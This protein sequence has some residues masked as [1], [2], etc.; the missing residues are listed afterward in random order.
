MGSGWR[1]CLRNYLQSA[2][3][4]KIYAAE[5]IKYIHAK[6]GCCKPSRGIYICFTLRSWSHKFQL[7]LKFFSVGLEREK[8]KILQ[9][10][11]T[12]TL[13]VFWCG[14]STAKRNGRRLSIVEGANPHGL[15]C[16]HD[17][18]IHTEYSMTWLITLVDLNGWQCYIYPQGTNWRAQPHTW[19]ILP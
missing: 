5:K 19:G 1:Q 3:W 12:S 10:L 16:D 4:Q 2:Y 18:W 17:G 8:M 9:K 15:K 13:L 11:L 6:N 7:K 14:V